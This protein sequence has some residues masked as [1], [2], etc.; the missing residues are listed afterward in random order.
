MPHT[1]TLSPYTTLFRSDGGTSGGPALQ[2]DPDL[3]AAITQRRIDHRERARCGRETG[4]R[5]EGCEVR[6][7]Q[8]GDHHV[9]PV[10]GRSEEHTSELQSRRELVCRLLLE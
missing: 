2:A 4:E 9:G 6:A 8:G 7:W 3:T 5:A 1:P 10:R